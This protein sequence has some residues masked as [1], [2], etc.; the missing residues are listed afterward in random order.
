MFIVIQK[1]YDDGNV[2]VYIKDPR[3]VIIDCESMLSDYDYY[4]DGF[5][6]LEIAKAFI[7]ECLEG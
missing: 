6:T 7:K 1:Y 5:E 4:E 2:E 3:E